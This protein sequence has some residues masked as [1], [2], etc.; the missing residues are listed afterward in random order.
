VYYRSV[1]RGAQLL[2]NIPADRRGLLP[3][4]DC[5]RAA[6]F[7]AEI[8]RRFAKSVAEVSGVGADLELRL[9]KP[10]RIDHVLLQ[11]DCS[12]GQRVRAFRLE[13]L[14]E[15]K[16]IGL[17]EGSS[18]GHKR[19]VPLAA[20]AFS[21]VRIRVTES[22]G[23]PH[24][25]RLAAFDTQAAPPPTWDAPTQIWAD[26]S[27]GRWDNSRFELDLSASIH[28]ATQFRLR[29]VPETGKVR[30]VENPSLL[31]DGAPTPHLLR[32]VPSRSDELILTMPGIGQKVVLRG[33]IEG[34]DHGTI[35]MKKL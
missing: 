31:L 22:A 15:S 12:L 8:K 29:F 9:P 2:L 34:A 13:G 17:Y 21:A 28:E 11:E 35:L 26:D 3:D 10:G 30:A 33:T 6:A 16:W 1:G 24:I 25:R 19:I 20:H 23:K 5:A 27:V 14:A 4:A 7:G 18:I 32:P